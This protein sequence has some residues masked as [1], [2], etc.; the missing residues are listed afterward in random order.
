M[1]LDRHEQEA[2]ENV[3]DAVSPLEHL[4]LGPAS[5]HRLLLVC[6]S[7][8]TLA[9]SGVDI[10][11][12][13]VHRIRHVVVDHEHGGG[14]SD[15]RLTECGRHQLVF[16]FLTLDHNHAPRLDVPG[17]GGEASD[18][19]DFSDL[20]FGDLFAGVLAD[21]LALLGGFGDAQDLIHCVHITLFSCVRKQTALD[22]QK[23]PPVYDLETPMENQHT[24]A[25]P[26]KRSESLDALRGIAILGMGLSGRLPWGTLPAWMYHAQSPPPGMAH[27]PKVFGISWVDL[28]FPFFLFA[29]GAALPFSLGKRAE[30]GASSVKIAVDILRRG[31][32]LVLFAVAAQHFRPDTLAPGKPGDEWV[33]GTLL[34]FAM[35]LAWGQFPRAWPA[36]VRHS[37]VALGVAGCVV[38]AF[39]LPFKGATTGWDWNRSDI[40]LLVLANVAVSGSAIWLLTRKHIWIRAGVV[41]AIAAAFVLRDQ[42]PALAQIWGWS[43][44][45]AVFR[46]E[47]HKYLLLVLPGSMVGDWL[48]AS[49]SD[50]ASHVFLS[51]RWIVGLS[52]LGLGVGACVGLLGRDLGMTAITCGLFGLAGFLGLRS[53]SSSY[54]RIGSFG[55]LMLAIGLAMEPLGG[56]IRKDPTTISYFFVTG[57]LAC[58]GLLFFNALERGTAWP[59]KAVLQSFAVAGANPM[60]AY[61]AITNLVPGVARLS[62]IHGW[63]NEQPWSPWGFAGYGLAQTVAVGIVAAVCTRSKIF[64]RT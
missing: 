38:A 23:F 58:W 48:R 51:D 26:G 49:R 29:L 56:G 47:F 55:L 2:N 34:F 53:E 39:L 63:A 5:E 36:W 17:R 64:M 6:L 57:G 11:D 20:R 31:A 12:G 18:P 15:L 8:P 13:V 24:D 14:G 19:E 42:Q 3:A 46:L 33:M 32:L 1:G 50:P 27:N 62:G 30:K 16:L 45:P 54:R 41:V 43:P 10:F 28:V 44:V 61:I 40:I 35:A 52:A 60:I 4:F 9:I 22:R 25:G 7:L 21:G 37:L 59:S